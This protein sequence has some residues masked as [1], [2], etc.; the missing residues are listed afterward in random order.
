M[1]PT[2]TSE[3]ARTSRAAMTVAV[4]D[5][6]HGL[7]SAYIAQYE[8]IKNPDSKQAKSFAE[9]VRTAIKHLRAIDRSL[10]KFD[11]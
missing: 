7:D 6:K 9:T 3:S 10:K 2:S 4:A 1:M 5:L 8:A 11:I